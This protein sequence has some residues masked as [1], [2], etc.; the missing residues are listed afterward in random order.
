MRQRWR[1]VPLWGRAWLTFTAAAGLSIV[2]FIA[3]LIWLPAIGSPSD[4]SVRYSLMRRAG[5]SMLTGDLFECQPRSAAVRVCDVPD[6]QNSG[7]AT[8]RVLME[9]RCWRARKVSPDAREEQI[10]PM[11]RR[12]SGCVEFRDQ[13]RLFERALGD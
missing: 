10:P 7:V 9:G 2:L 4:D 12:V 1:E 5:G 3:A 6:I 11:K 13:V 8:Y